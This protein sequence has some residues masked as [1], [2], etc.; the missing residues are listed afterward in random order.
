VT[1]PLLLLLAGL[2]VQDPARPKDKTDEA[3]ERGVKFLAGVA[4][5]DGAI[6]EAPANRTAMTA[7]AVLAMA[8]TGNQP[9]DETPAGLAMRRGLAFMLK[10]QQDPQGFFGSKDGSRMYGH[11][12]ITLTLSEM[13]GMGVDAQMDQVL[14]D[15]CKK[16]VELILRSQA[17][18]KDDRSAGGWRYMPDSRDSDLSVTVWQLMALRSAKNAG[19]DVPKESI[20]RAV[21]YVK[22][23]FKGKKGPDGKLDPAV[24]GACAY[25][26]GH[27]PEYAMAAAG[28]LSLQICGDYESPEVASSADWLKERKLEWNREWFFYGTYYYSQGMFQRGGDYAVHGRRAVEEIVLPKQGPDGSWRAQHGSEQSAGRVYGTAM[29]L[30]CLAVRNHYLPIYQR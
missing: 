12:I 13:L 2:L 11:G 29:A 30:L 15:R 24:K 23:C 26:P 19:L 7:L 27:N 1:A 28:L 5:K 9:T 8:A 17:M 4:D 6:A 16:A 10:D 18:P 22:R 25:E 3:I 14:R 20:E 21:A